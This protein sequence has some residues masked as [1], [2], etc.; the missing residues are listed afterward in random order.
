VCQVPLPT[1]P[2]LA[3]YTPAEERGWGTPLKG[4]AIETK[5]KSVLLLNYILLSVFLF[6]YLLYYL[7]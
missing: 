2:S 3:Q 6:G 1:K 4:I 7:F 5:Y